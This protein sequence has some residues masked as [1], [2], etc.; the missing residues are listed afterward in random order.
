MEE[1]KKGEGVVDKALRLREVC[2]AEK[3]QGAAEAAEYAA[4]RYRLLPP[5]PGAGC[6]HVPVAQCRQGEGDA[7]Q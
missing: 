7:K 2:S 3:G 4:A 5:Q 1:H 6:S